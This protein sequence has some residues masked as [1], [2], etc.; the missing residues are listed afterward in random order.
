MTSPT[1]PPPVG[2]SKRKRPPPMGIRLI[3]VSGFGLAG[4]N[5]TRRWF[6]STTSVSAD[7]ERYRPAKRLQAGSHGTVLVAGTDALATASPTVPINW[8]AITLGKESSP[9]VRT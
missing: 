2:A 1:T 8:V 4:S 6:S 5:I 9:L 7:G 3:G